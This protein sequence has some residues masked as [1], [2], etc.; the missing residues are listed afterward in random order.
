MKGDDAMEMLR[1]IYNEIS[2]FIKLAY[3]LASQKISLA[4]RR[5]STG[6]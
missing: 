2:C 5:N 1:Y 4:L 6:L 3:D